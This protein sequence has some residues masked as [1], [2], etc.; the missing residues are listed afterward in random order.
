M[1]A[2]CHAAN[3][4]VSSHFEDEDGKVVLPAEGEGR[5]IHDAKVLFERLLLGDM[6]VANGRRILSVECKH[7]TSETP[8]AWLCDPT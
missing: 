8:P 2:L 3:R 6:V 5:C 1:T 4:A 7:E